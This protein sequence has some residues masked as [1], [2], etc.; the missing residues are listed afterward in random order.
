MGAECGMTNP[1]DLDVSHPARQILMLTSEIAEPSHLPLPCQFWDI[2]EEGY[3][4]QCGLRE[5]DLVV[6]PVG[7]RFRFVDKAAVD[8]AMPACNFSCAAQGTTG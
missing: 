4:Y 7:S 5:F 1:Y 3:G 8:D 6:E 2:A